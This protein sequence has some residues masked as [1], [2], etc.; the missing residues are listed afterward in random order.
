MKFSQDYISNQNSYEKNDVKWIVIH[1]TDNFNKGADAKAHAKAQHDGNFDGMSAHCYVDD[2]SIAYDVMPPERG[3]W[4][5]GVNY[6]GKLFGTVSNRNSY[7]IEM[8][9][10]A[11]YDYEKAFSNLVK[12]CKVKMD[13]LGIDAAH[14]VSHYDVCGKNCPSQIRAKGDWERFKNLIG[15]EGEEIPESG[16]GTEVDRLYRVRKSWEDAES[17]RGAYR[18]L[19]NAKNDCPPGWT[20]YDWNGEAVYSNTAA[21]TGTQTSEFVDLSEKEAAA[22]LLEICRPISVSYGLFPS[23][24]AAQTILES[25]YCKTELARKANNVCGMKCNLSGNTWSGSTWDGKSK[26]SILTPEQDGAGNIYYVFADFRMYPNIEESIKDRC[27]YLLEALDG[28]ELRYAGI[29]DCKN[30]TEQINLIKKGEY[31]TD[32]NYVSK[33]CDIIDRFELSIYDGDITENE[34]ESGETEEPE[35]PGE[36]YTVQAGAYTVREN[37]EAR[38]QK[39]KAAGFDSFI[40]FEDNF[41]KIQAGAYELKEN[42]EKQ[43]ER[44]KAAGFSAFIR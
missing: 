10:Q 29:Q 42:A 18:I 40:F 5:V 3:A 33:I 34:E 31:A 37:A 11:G 28:S 24:C 6:G 35:R 43:V 13:E 30:Y 41:Y 38:V 2:G 16:N 9:V 7:G 44:L 36:L 25:G 39:L 15:A 17:Q 19:E 12:V 27:A 32:V 4:H 14:V 20:V 21:V 26:V 8:C 23:V 1:N 22:R